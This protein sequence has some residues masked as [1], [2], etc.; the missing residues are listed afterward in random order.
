MT[1]RELLE[2]LT[3]DV[4]MMRTALAVHTESHTAQMRQCLRHADMIEKHDHTLYGNGKPGLVTEI[5][6]LRWGIGLVGVI[7][8]A[9]VVHAIV[10]L[11]V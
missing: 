7:S 9:L 6:V 3:E 5:A 2:R 4:G 10:K 8:T 1:D 11:F